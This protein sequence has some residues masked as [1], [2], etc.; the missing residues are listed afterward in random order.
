MA[1]IQ[2]LSF[3][4]LTL[5]SEIRSEHLKFHFKLEGTLYKYLIFGGSWW[6]RQDSNLGPRDYES[7]D[8]KTVNLGSATV[9]ENSNQP[10]LFKVDA[11]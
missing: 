4:V 10:D 5:P 6:A 2:T 11:E 7:P 3:W 1:P 8:L 9:C